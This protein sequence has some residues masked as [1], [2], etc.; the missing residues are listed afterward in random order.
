MSG[1]S[2]LTLLVLVA[3]VIAFRRWRESQ[4]TSVD[5]AADVTDDVTDDLTGDD[6]FRQPPAG[7]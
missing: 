6:F 2:P 1:T 5:A 7:R 3:A 4:Q